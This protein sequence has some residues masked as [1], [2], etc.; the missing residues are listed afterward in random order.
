MTEKVAEGLFDLEE[1]VRDAADIVQAIRMLGSSEEI[2]KDHKGPII[3][4]AQL[5]LDKLE[6]VAKERTRLAVLAAS[7]PAAPE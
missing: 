5:A 6:L 1:P 4:L 2:S 7:Q 3:T